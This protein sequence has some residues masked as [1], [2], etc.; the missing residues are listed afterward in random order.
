MTRSAPVQGTSFD[1]FGTLIDVDRTANPA[2]RIAREL[3]ARGVSVPQDWNEAYRTPQVDAARYEEVP[4][5]IHVRAVLENRSV[6][7][8][9]PQSSTVQD[10]VL[11]A[12]DAT[13]Q[14]RSGA[15]ST[16]EAT[17][18]HGPVG[19]LSNCSV[20]GLVERS[21]AKSALDSEQF[22]VVVT[23]V[24][25]GWRKPDPRAFEAITAHLDVPL[26]ALVHIGDDPETD[27]GASKTGA[28]AVLVN[29]VPLTDVPDFITQDG[30]DC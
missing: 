6:D 11:A 25:C 5:P 18:K 19:I 27:G 9:S 13:V 8:P 15:V 10:A 2:P 30:G 16:V 12:F 3:S 7:V 17:A 29:E 23:S 1:C 4:L 21:L 24:D 14:T 26:S 20:P 22:D 28:T